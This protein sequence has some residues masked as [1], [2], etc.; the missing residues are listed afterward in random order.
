[1]L[2]AAEALKGHGADPMIFNDKG[3][4]PLGTLELIDFAVA[5]E[6]PTAGCNTLF[7]RCGYV[8]GLKLKIRNQLYGF[9]KMM[10]CRE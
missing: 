8:E 3:Y 4:T 9:K 5:Y 10:I 7:C 1:M 2:K 6:C